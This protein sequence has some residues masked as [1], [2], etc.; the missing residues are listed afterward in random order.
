MPATNNSQP[1]SA[2][3]SPHGSLGPTDDCYEVIDLTSE[4]PEPALSYYSPDYSSASLVLPSSPKCKCLYL[5]SSVLR[6]HNS[7]L[8]FLHTVTV[9][10]IHNKLL[11]Y[12]PYSSSVIIY[13]DTILMLLLGSMVNIA[14][15]CNLTH[16]C[17]YYIV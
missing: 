13:F 10:R 4:S 1:P 9:L 17:C 2:T 12:L 6:L 11:I 7:L 8:I 15:T 5:N 16:L 14:L 3:P